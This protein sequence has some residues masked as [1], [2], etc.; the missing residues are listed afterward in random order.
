[1]FVG[2]PTLTSM[3][4]IC[5][6]NVSMPEWIEEPPVSIRIYRNFLQSTAAP[7][8]DRICGSARLWGYAESCLTLSPENCWHFSLTFVSWYLLVWNKGLMESRYRN[9][10]QLLFGQGV[11]AVSRPDHPWTTAGCCPGWLPPA[12]GHWRTRYGKYLRSILAL[13]CD[14]HQLS[15]EFSVVMRKN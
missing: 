8:N 6:A 15:C 2:S 7:F 9:D 1:M 10:L 12:D 13:H 4:S 3:T 11:W 5:S 14:G